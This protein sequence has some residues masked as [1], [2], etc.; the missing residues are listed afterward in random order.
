M[1]SLAHANGRV[2]YHVVPDSKFGG[3]LIKQQKQ[4]QPIS[5]HRTKAEAVAAGKALA[6]S[7]ALGQLIIHLSNGRIETEFT[8]GK[9]PAN[10]AG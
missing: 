9:D 1:Q 10:S 3:W 6:K 5:S 8:Y 7:H 4:T 2:V